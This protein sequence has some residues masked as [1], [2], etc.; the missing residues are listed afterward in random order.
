MADN[1]TPR[2]SFCGVEKSPTVPLIAGNEGRICEA[3]VKLAHQ[4]VNSWG[5]R[6]KSQEMAPQLRTPAEYKRHL[7]ESVVGQEAAKETLAV[8]VYSHYLRL[9]NCNQDPVCQLSEQVELE[10]SNILMAGPSGTGK[11]LLVRTLARI[12]GVPFASA[13]ATTLTQAGY[14]GDDVD[15]IIA[16]LLDAAGGDVQQAQWGIVYIDEVDKLAK[17]SGG[18]TAVRDISGEGVQQAL[19]KMV[20][21][22][23][24]RISKSGR[25]NDHGEE[26]VVDTRNILFIAGGAFPGLEALV[27]SRIQPKDTAIGFHAQHRPKAPSINELLASL[28]PDDLHEFGLIPEFI[29][30]FPIITFLQELDHATLLRILTEPRNALVK[31]YKQLFAYQ[32]VALDITDEALNYIADQA[33]LRKTGARGLRAVLEAALQRTMF[34]MPSLPQLRRC[35]LTLAEREGEGTKL[36]VQRHMADEETETPLEQD[37]PSFQAAIDAAE[38]SLM[39]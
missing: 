23:E 22:S 2:C 1:E 32:G 24:V 31:Q 17:R 6:R 11:T 30:R 20:E 39:G 29:G 8:A 19:L 18:G 38:S 36:E 10:K 26:L 9:L 27:S 3:C 21:G 16:R 14:V 28:L 5:Q 25:K 4:V 37:K 12:L 7:D 13:D 35:T 15:S 34:D 33:L